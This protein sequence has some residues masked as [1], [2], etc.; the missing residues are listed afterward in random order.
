MLS[1]AHLRP[2]PLSTPP[3]CTS[4][5]VE[6]RQ[7]EQVVRGISDQPG[8]PGPMSM[9]GKPADPEGLFH[10]WDGGL[11]SRELKRVLSVP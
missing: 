4:E 3:C 1:W 7:P 11:H 2:H 8:E 6:C 5:E 9:M 10:S